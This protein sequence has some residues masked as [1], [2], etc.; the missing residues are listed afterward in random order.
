MPKRHSKE[1][2]ALTSDKCWQG[3]NPFL[4]GTKLFIEKEDSKH[5]RNR[6]S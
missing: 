2:D 3:L 1:E 4:S 6:A 5:I